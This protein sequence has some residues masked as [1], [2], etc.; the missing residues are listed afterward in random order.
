LGEEVGVGVGG[1]VVDCFAVG[2]FEGIVGVVGEHVLVDVAVEECVEVGLLFLGF[3]A[4]DFG[5]GCV[6]G[7]GSGVEEG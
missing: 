6:C 2:G 7:G 1:G 4:F 3:G 5:G